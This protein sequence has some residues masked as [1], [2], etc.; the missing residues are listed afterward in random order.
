[1]IV[2]INWTIIT[3]NVPIFLPNCSRSWAYLNAMSQHACIKL[4]HNHRWQQT[5]EYACK[6]DVS[7]REQ[8][9][10][11]EHPFPVIPSFSYWTKCNSTFTSMVNIPTPFIC[12]MAQMC[13]AIKQ[14]YSI[15]MIC[16]PKFYQILSHYVEVIAVQKLFF[17]LSKYYS[18]PKNIYN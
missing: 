15:F 16:G 6:L 18:I 14:I 1:M 2:H 8:I 17:G 10:R 9:R 13:K 4:K 5:L 3:W 11:L 7:S 12:Y